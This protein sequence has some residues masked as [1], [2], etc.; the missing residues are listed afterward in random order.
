LVHEYEFV[1]APRD[2]A[3]GAEPLLEEAIYLASAGQPSACVAPG[4][5]PR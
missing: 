3:L 5:R 4:R 1:P 2:P